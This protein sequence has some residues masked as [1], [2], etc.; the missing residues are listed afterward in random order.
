[1]FN[2]ITL[3]GMQSAHTPPANRSP[4]PSESP[5]TNY[6]CG[7]DTRNSNTDQKTQVIRANPPSHPTGRPWGDNRGAG[8]MVDSNPRLKEYYFGPHP[9]S[10]FDRAYKK[11]GNF[12]IDNPDPNDRADR[13]YDFSQVVGYITSGTD[14]RA[15]PTPGR[16]IYDGYNGPGKPPTKNSNYE[17]FLN[18][19]ENGYSA[20]KDPAKDTEKNK[21]TDITEHN[22]E[23]KTSD[24]P[25]DTEKTVTPKTT[26]P[27]ISGTEAKRP[28][29]NTDVAPTGPTGRP[30]WDKRLAGQILEE[31]REIVNSR[32]KIIPDEWLIEVVGNYTP[33]NPDP[34]SQANA[35]YYLVRLLH[36]IDSL[37][38]ELSH[39]N[40]M[41]TDPA[42]PEKNFA[43]Y[44]YKNNGKI[45]GERYSPLPPPFNYATIDAGSEAAI[46]YRVAHERSYSALPTDKTEYSKQT[47]IAYPEV[48]ALPPK[49]HNYEVPT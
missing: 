14:S 32:P 34:V 49:K 39:R 23:A 20:L 30:E 46:L 42:D 25:P 16:P 15:S 37:T 31:N 38:T 48:G 19:L 43:P 44:Q 4:C 8:E 5:A 2:L 13:M 21:K 10:D 3:N 35:A 26:T 41:P 11:V 1:M 27:P 9:E 24:T 33:S 12:S 22:R 28:E 18:F 29:L 17:L 6:P 7:P 45:D 47:K 36:Y 40:H